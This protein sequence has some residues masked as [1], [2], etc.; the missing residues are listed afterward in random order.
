MRVSS[1]ILRTRSNA[2]RVNQV[3]SIQLLVLIGAFLAM[4]IPSRPYP[5]PQSVTPVKRGRVRS[6]DPPRVQVVAFGIW[7][8]LDIAKYVIV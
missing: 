5:E 2:N 6:S 1:R 4:S 3:I 8:I 7:E